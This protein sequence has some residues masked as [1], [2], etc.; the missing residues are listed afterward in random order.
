YDASKSR[1]ENYEDFVS[2]GDPSAGDPN[3]DVI[4]IEFFD[5]NCPHCKTLHPLMKAA[6]DSLGSQARF[7]F[8]PFVLRPSSLMQIEALHIAA[9][10]G[11]FFEMLDAQYAR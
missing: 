2:F 5:P 10:Q 6:V 9:Q 7:V 3:S 8:R 1:V 4:V 11:K